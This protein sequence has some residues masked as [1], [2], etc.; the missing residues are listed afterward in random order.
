MTKVEEQAL[1]EFMLDIDCIEQLNKWNDNFN[2]F[3]VLR[4]TNVEI[5]HSNILA[6]LLDPNEN[7]GL[8]DSFIKSFISKVV[9]K[10]KSN[11]FSVIEILLQNFYSYQVHRELNNMD[12]ILQSIDE[13]T[14]VIIENKIWSK[15]STNQLKKYYEKSKTEYKDYDKILYVF[16]TPN[17]IESSEPDIWIKFSYKEIIESLEKAIE[18]KKLRDEVLLLT[19]NYIGIVRKEIMKE[20]D[21]NLV[22][23][24]NEIYNKHRTALKLIFENVSI[25]NSSDNE[26]ILSTLKEM[27]D[28]G[29]I[30]IKDEKKRQF[31]TKTMDEFL[32]SLKEK[33]SS[34]GTDWVYYYWFEKCGEKLVIHLEL[35]GWN[36]TDELTKKTNSLI[37]VSKKTVDDYRYKRIY[38]KDKKISS[39]D[40]NY[41]TSLK[42]AVKYLV[43]CALKNE[44]RIIAEAKK[45]LSNNSGVDMF[46]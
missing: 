13:K 3:D 6:W 24:C 16:L 4:I 36:L 26:I 34:W 30:I 18:T 17:G 23:I 11:K 42:E 14:V 40:D 45:I 5:R 12:I 20:K 46:K 32:P 10:Y 22:L 1:K 31:F 35:G 41:E 2:V 39:D 44:K 28:N 15:E 21:E 9:S 19:K 8:G 43:N 25:D 33:K 38:H 27:A 29:E 7:H 37:K